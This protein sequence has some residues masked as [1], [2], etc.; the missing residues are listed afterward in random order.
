[1]AINSKSGKL[2]S[3]RSAPKSTLNKGKMQP[4][5]AHFVTKLNGVN[6]KLVC[7][8]SARA[9]CDVITDGDQQER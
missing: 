1:M 3:S 7:S 4:F 5:G 2:G 8:L 9:V 6:N